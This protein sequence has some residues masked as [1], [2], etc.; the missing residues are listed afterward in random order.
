MV[1]AF[2]GFCCGVCEIS[3]WANV[4]AGV[5]VEEVASCAGLAN[6]LGCAASLLVNK[7]YVAQIALHYAQIDKEL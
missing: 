2:A 5:V 3:G 7:Y 6:L 4:E 1:A